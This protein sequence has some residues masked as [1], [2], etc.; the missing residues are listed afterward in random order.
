MK[1]I[2][3]GAVVATLTLAS[4]A[5]AFGPGSGSGFGMG[6]GR[7][8]AQQQAV[9]NG[10]SITQDTSPNWGMGRGQGR[11]Q[12]FGRGMGRHMGGFQGQ[13]M[14]PQTTNQGNRTGEPVFVGSW[15][16]NEDGIVSLEEATSGRDTYF[17]SLDDDEDGVI[18]A[19][20][21]NEF[22]T[23]TRMSPE[24]ATNGQRGLFGMTLGFN[25]VN[26]DAKVD[27]E[28][29]LGQTAA[30]LKGMDRNGDGQVSNADFGPRRAQ[31]GQSGSAGQ[32][33]RQGERQGVGC[34][35]GPRGPMRG[36]QQQ[37]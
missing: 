12:G 14:A 30:W 24:E 2:T 20:E 17:D 27:R 7:W 35:S 10:Q 15:D 26:K 1:L 33:Q 4:T 32:G 19:T 16:E 13:V 28:E 3:L 6:Q 34:G 36:F 22:L 9:N 23:N 37:G 29:F 18:V 5:L 11:M 21:F 8:M 31:M 25:D